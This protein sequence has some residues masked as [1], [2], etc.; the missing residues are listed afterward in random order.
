MGPAAFRQSL[1]LLA[2][3]LLGR[4]VLAQPLIRRMPQRIS[5]GPFCKVTCATSLG[6]IQIAPRRARLATPFEEGLK[7]A[8]R[9][10]CEAVKSPDL[11]DL[12]DVAPPGA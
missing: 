11:G 10:I 6:L 3:D 2:D 7:P 1:F 12:D 8:L 5:A 9:G 4:L